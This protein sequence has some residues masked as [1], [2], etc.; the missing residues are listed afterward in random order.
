MTHTL[1]LLPRKS[2]GEGEVLLEQASADSR[3]QACDPLF[4]AL[5]TMFGD[6]NDSPASR[7]VYTRL[8][9][10]NAGAGSIMSRPHRAQTVRRIARGPLGG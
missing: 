4:S 10:A 2:A 3:A 9:I 6:G 1:P 8:C 7:Q 5:Q